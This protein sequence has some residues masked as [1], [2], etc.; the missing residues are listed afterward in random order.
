MCRCYISYTSPLALQRWFIDLASCIVSCTLHRDCH[1]FWSCVCDCTRFVSN[2]FPGNFLWLL[3][4][5]RKSCCNV[6][7][8]S[9]TC[10]FPMADVNFSRL[11]LVLCDITLGSDTDKE[12]TQIRIII[13]NSNYII[14]LFSEIIWLIK[15]LL[16]S[17]SNN[18]LFKS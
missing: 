15:F 13:L 5:S 8:F 1:S 12:Q 4:R 11:Q 17:Y 7:S 18:Y 3:Q 9:S 10:S 14:S 2:Y 16:L 6:K